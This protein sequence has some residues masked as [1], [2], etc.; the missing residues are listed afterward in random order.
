MGQDAELGLARACRQQVH[1][2]FAVGSVDADEGGELGG[3]WG[4]HSV[5]PEVLK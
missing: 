4:I 3:G 1:V 5:P 2:V